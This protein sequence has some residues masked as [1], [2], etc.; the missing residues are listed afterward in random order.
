MHYPDKN[1]DI[2]LNRCAKTNALSEKEIESALRR[3]IAVRV[4]NR[5]DEISQSINAGMPISHGRKSNLPLA[6]DHWADKL[7]GE[8]PASAEKMS[9]ETKGTRGWLRTFGL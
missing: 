3:P 9:E 1:I 2:V 4:P 5:F 6:F 8:G 7:F